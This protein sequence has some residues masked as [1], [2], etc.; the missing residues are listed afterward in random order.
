MPT[1]DEEL[2]GLGSGGGSSFEDELNALGSES[3][4]DPEPVREMG[5]TGGLS[6]AGSP[7]DIAAWN[8]GAERAGTVDAAPAPDMDFSAQP[9]A[10]PAR[11][12]LEGAYDR[13]FNGNAQRGQDRMV[14]SLAAQGV[15]YQQPR[16]YE[17]ALAMSGAPIAAGAA[18]GAISGARNSQADSF[19]GRALDTAEGALY[20]G[21]AGG[22]SRALGAGS[23][24]F[25]KAAQW[26]GDKIDD[27][28]SSPT[29]QKAAQWAGSAAGGTAGTA[30][31]AG[32][33]F[34]GAAAAG[35]FAGTAAG[36]YLAPKAIPAAGAAMRGMGNAAQGLGSP[37]MQAF[38]SV[39]AADQIGGNLER[40]DNPST[41]ATDAGRGNL[42]G[43]A[44]LEAL[45]SNPTV[46]GAYAGEFA[47]AAASP[48]V[49]AVNTLI[50]K[51]A[52]KDPAFRAGP[53][54]ELQ[55]MTAEY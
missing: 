7:T 48:E 55:R 17:A 25:G 8:S 52:Q 26:A 34:P 36:G 11:G 51:L 46:L 45:Q 31:G 13:L 3:Q 21:L 10:V 16:P 29:V 47:K 22:A 18:S 39:T 41:N 37:A 19:G 38:G 2:S 42:L 49:G 20:G 9:M 23:K 40:S 30:L 14:E 5:S 15:D 44:A 43:D 24:Y 54:V 28:G 53:M 4:P 12:G 33:P 32:M 1:F 50:T 35:G 27:F 6:F